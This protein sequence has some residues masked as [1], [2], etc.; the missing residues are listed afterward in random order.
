MLVYD[1]TRNDTAAVGGDRWQGPPHHGVA[2]EHGR[3]GVKP[4]PKLFVVKIN[5]KESAHAEGRPAQTCHSCGGVAWSIL[6]A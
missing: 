6:A 3:A 1:K 5:R 4:D 2:R